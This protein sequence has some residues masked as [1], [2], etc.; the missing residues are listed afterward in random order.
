MGDEIKKVTNINEITTQVA[1]TIDTLIKENEKSISSSEPKKAEEPKKSE[2]PKKAEEPKKK[3]ETP[4]LE[5]L[6]AQIADMETKGKKKDEE[7]QRRID[8]LTSEK[9]RLEAQLNKKSD[10]EPPQSELDKQLATV[11]T[12]IKHNRREQ[13]KISKQI[14]NETDEDVIKKLDDKLDQLIL[15]EKKFEMALHALKGKYDEEEN[16]KKES[17]VSAQA[18]E[19]HKLTLKSWERAAKD[20]PGILDSSGKFDFK[21]PVLKLA[22]KLLHATNPQTPK[23]D[24]MA[25]SKGLKINPAFDHAEGVYYAIMEA[26]RLIALESSKKRNDDNAATEEAK[27]NK[28]N[29]ESELL[30]PGGATTT[31]VDT[32]SKITKLQQD[33]DGVFNELLEANKT[34][35]DAFRGP[36][37]RK[38]LKLVEEQRKLKEKET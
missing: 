37:G 20:F 6:Q 2:E 30:Q 3:P 11:T 12:E 27:R 4:T 33:I 22:I 21:T 5:D 38:W 14:D 34:D 36:L 35:A 15:E 8:E 13:L 31:T 9:K 18:E 26:D 32:R 19:N 16:K 7:V 24:L 25:K 29:L 17:E 23:F 10:T 1:S 28:K